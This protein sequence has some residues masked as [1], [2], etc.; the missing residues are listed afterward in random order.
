MVVVKAGG[1]GLGAAAARAAASA[2]AMRVLNADTSLRGDQ[3]TVWTDTV[4]V[5]VPLHKASSL[6]GICS[7]SMSMSAA[8]PGT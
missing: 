2:A 3:H 1:G 5:M 6:N 4:K 8:W 7:A